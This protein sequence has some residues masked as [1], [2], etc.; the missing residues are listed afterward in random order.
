MK[1]YIVI[2]LLLISGSVVHAQMLGLKTNLLKDAACTPNIAL[3]VALG[4]HI[5]LSTELCGS[6]NIYG[7]KFK[8]FGVAPEVR[9]W[10]E[11][12]CYKGFF[13]GIGAKAIHYDYTWKKERRRGDAGGVGVT[14]G[15]DF[16]FRD[17]FA[18][19]VHAGLGAMAHWQSHYSED[20]P[21]NLSY[22]ERGLSIVPYQLGV[23]FIYI[24]K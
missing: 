2:I 1:R 16:F 7:T 5:S 3:D 22:R 20:N 4:G 6:Y 9:Y 23:S 12:R 17:H 21:R 24:I 15:Y 19:D 18:I 14:F 8:T 11:G 13:L 10:Y